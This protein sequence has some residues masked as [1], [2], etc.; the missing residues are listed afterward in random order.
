MAV[1]SLSSVCVEVL[2]FCSS[3]NVWAMQGEQGGWIGLMASI[4]KDGLVGSGRL[5]VDGKGGLAGRLSTIIKVQSAKDLAG[6]PCSAAPETP[7]IPVPET[8]GI[9]GTKWPGTPGAEDG[10]AKPG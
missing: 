2:R 7:G 5:N 3:S 6:A 9:P 4:G 8:P 1:S 10:R